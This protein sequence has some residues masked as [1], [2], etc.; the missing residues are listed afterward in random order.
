MVYVFSITLLF[1]QLAEDT[2]LAIQQTYMETSNK[3]NVSWLMALQ[4]RNSPWYRLH[5]S[6]C[7]L[8]STGRMQLHWTSF[9]NFCKLLSETHRWQSLP[10]LYNVTEHCSCTQHRI[11]NFDLPVSNVLTYGTRWLDE[12]WFAITWI[13][14]LDQVLLMLA[15]GVTCSRHCSCCAFL[16]RAKAA[17]ATPIA[18]LVRASH[19]IAFTMVSTCCQQVWENHPK[20][21]ISQS[22]QKLSH[23]ATCAWHEKITFHPEVNDKTMPLMTI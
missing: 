19:M 4:P 20:A 23:H 8:S 1:G 9:W 22:N 3:S 17:A 15:D 10:F 18:R 14:S 13:P 2:C 12:S 21:G 5:P 16:W 11:I 6:N 7:L